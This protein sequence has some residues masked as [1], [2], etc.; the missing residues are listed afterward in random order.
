MRLTVQPET[1]GP[2]PRRDRR[3]G[4]DVLVVFVHRLTHSFPSSKSTTQHPL[5]CSSPDRQ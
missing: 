4:L 2:L 3:I 5:T 1:T